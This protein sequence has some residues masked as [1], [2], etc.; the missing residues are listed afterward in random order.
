MAPTDPLIWQ[1]SY[2]DIEI[3]KILERR[4]RALVNEMNR[5]AVYSQGGIRNAA[6]YKLMEDAKKDKEAI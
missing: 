2:L 3:Q 4:D 5:Y 6:K 1:L